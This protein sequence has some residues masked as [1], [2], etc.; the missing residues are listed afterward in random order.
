MRRVNGKEK[1]KSSA[2]PASDQDESY[3]GISPLL[4]L[5]LNWFSLARKLKYGATTKLTRE[6]NSLPGQ[7]AGIVSTRAHLVP[8]MKLTYI[9]CGHM[10]RALI[11]QILKRRNESVRESPGVSGFELKILLC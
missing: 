2:G 8:A 4:I 6:S 11:L 1:G 9:I 10:Y 5:F 7:D 3:F